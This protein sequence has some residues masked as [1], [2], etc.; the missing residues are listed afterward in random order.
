LGFISKGQVVPEFE[1]AAFGLKTGEISPVIQ[2]AFGLHILKVDEIQEQKTDP[3]DKVKGQIQTFLQTR[4]AREIAHDEADQAYGAAVKEKTLEG[5]AKEKGLSLKETGIFSAADKVDLDP[6]LKDAALSLGKGDVSPVLRLGETFAVL[7]VLEKQEARNPELKEVEA[8][9][10]EAAR[11][12]KQ[13]GKASA[14]AKD[15]LE[16]LRQG[17]EWKSLMAREGLKIEETGFFERALDPPKIGSSEDFRKAVQ[18]AGPQIL[19]RKTRSLGTGNTR[20]SASRRKRRLIR[21]SSAPRRKTSASA[22][23]SKNRRGFS[24]AGWTASWN[25]P[26]RKG[27]SKCTKKPTKS[28]KNRVQGFE[29]AR[30][31]GKGL[32]WSLVCNRPRLLKRFEHCETN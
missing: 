29:E 16:K 15:L 13:K 5:F 1:E 7:Q 30:G 9:V 12:E 10:F 24:P 4:Q 25:G 26:K 3:L 6:K 11:L 17:A 2:T 23:C 19:T 31:R 18:G 28:F 27:I 21:P 32:P 20:S 14:K 22:F 8:K